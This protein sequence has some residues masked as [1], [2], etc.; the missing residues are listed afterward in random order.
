MQIFSK[1][2]KNTLVQG[3][4]RAGTVIVS[5]VL[6]GLLYR[7]LQEERFGAYSFI[8]AFVL[9]FGHLSDWGTNIITVREAVK[10]KERQ[11]EIFGSLI[12]FRFVLAVL[13]FLLVNLV[14]RLNPAWQG[15]I[16]TTTIASFVLLFLSFKTSAQM[17]FQ[18]L[19][20]LDLTAVVDFL[21]SLFFLL[22]V[23]LF[24]LV[25]P[26][27][28]KLVM[29]AWVLATFTVAVIGLVLAARISRINWIFEWNAVKPVFTAAIP[30]GAMLITF[31]LYNRIDIVILQQ[32]RGSTEVA[33]YA[34]AY[35]VYDNTVLAAAF[36]MNALFPYLAQEFG[37]KSYLLLRQYYQ[38]AFDVLLVFGLL[39]LSIIIVFAPQIVEILTGSLNNPAIGVLRVLSFAIIVAYFNH[40]NGFSL[41]AFGLQKLSFMIALVALIFNAGANFIFVPR[42]SYTAAAVITVATELL[43][44]LIST[45]VIW[46]NIGMLPSLFSFP[47]TISELIKRKI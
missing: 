33:P 36:L 34:L 32:F 9:L 2:L 20:R 13:S 35:K 4:S 28:I 47:K 43:V 16:T 1:V 10:E 22:L 24:L 27:D 19:V 23:F 37:R 44:L 40:L 29:L 14:V 25:Y 41:I 46:K 18:A 7:Q 39:V 3:L 11:P 30:T 38:K 42:Y 5:I 6:T 21:A 17:V 8:T 31:S 45:I 12:I 26:N 15:L